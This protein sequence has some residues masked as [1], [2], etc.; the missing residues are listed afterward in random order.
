M[1]ICHSDN[2][3]ITFPLDYIGEGLQHIELGQSGAQTSGGV[4]IVQFFVFF[5]SK[6]QLMPLPPG[7]DL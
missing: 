5:S 4:V 2:P 1:G 7:T 6:L 3:G